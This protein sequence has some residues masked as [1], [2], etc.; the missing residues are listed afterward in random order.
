M[1]QLESSGKL[2]NSSGEINFYKR[3]V[4]QP[5]DEVVRIHSEFF[6]KPYYK[7]REVLRLL[8]WWS[9]KHYLKILFK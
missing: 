3:I 4:D 8:L 1:A 6:K 2:D 9:L 5:M 7:Q